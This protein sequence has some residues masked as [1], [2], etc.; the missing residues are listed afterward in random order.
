M[1]VLLLDTEKTW[2]GGQLQVQLLLSGLIQRGVEAHL[3]A[4]CHGELRDRTQGTVPLLPIKVRNDLD[5]LAVFSLAR[6]CRQ[7]H[8]DLID[9]H[10]ARAHSIGAWTKMLLPETRLVVHRHID[11]PPQPSLGNRFLYGTHRVDRFVAISEKIRQ[12]LL[13]YNIDANRINVVRSAVDPAPFNQLDRGEARPRLAR[14][15]NIPPERT[16]LG[17]AGQLAGYKDHSMLLRALKILQDSAVESH[18][19]IA[20]EGN[21]RTALESEIV[22][23]GLDSAVTL[24]GFRRD[25]PDLLAALDVFV[26]PSR[27]EGLGLAVLEAFHAGTCVVATSA[28]GIPEMVIAGKTGL[29]SAPG[30]SVAFA[31]NLAQAIANP[32]LRQSLAMEARNFAFREFSLDA[33]V[34]GNL[35]LYQEIISK[36]TKP[37]T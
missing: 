25:I 15:L 14:E 24:L 36:N 1:H 4:A 26:M 13:D 30:D 10:S 16:L 19:V 33:M 23:L 28:G 32:R 12:V 22:Q 7:R 34:E 8:I 5:P 18:C 3:A 17:T 11:L 6:Y 37:R 27:T 31:A 35:A 2:A 29:L 20:G 21:R 9:A